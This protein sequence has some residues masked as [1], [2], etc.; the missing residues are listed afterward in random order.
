VANDQGE[1]DYCYLQAQ[2]SNGEFTILM[3]W[4]SAGFH[5][6][7]YNNDWSLTKGEDFQALV[8]IDKRFNGLIAASTNSDVSIDYVFGFDEAPRKAFQEGSRIILEG[9]AGKK[10]FRLQGTRKAVTLLLDCADEYF[11]TTEILADESADIGNPFTLE[12]LGDNL[13]AAGDTVLHPGDRIDVMF[14]AL[15]DL[16]ERS[17][18]GFVADDAAQSPEPYHFNSETIK[19]RSDGTMVLEVPRMLG[20]YR[21]WMYDRANGIMLAEEKLRIEVDTDSAGLDLPGGALLEPGQS[22]DVNFRASPNYSS[23]AWVGVLDA[24][25]PKDTKIEWFP[26]GRFYLDNRAD[27]TLTFTAPAS[28]GKYLLRMQEL[29]FAT[30]LTEIMLTVAEPMAAQPQPAAANTALSLASEAPGIA[31][32]QPVFAPDEGIAVIYGGLPAKGQDWLAIAGVDQGPKEYYDLVM[33][34]GRP[35]DGSHVFKPLPEGE[36]Q[37]RLYTDWPKGGYEI[38]A[39]AR[40][41]VAL[42]PALP[43]PAQPLP[44]PAAPLPAQPVAPTAAVPAPPA[45]EPPT[46][47]PPATLAFPAPETGPAPAKTEMPQAAEP[48]TPDAIPF[49]ATR[50]ASEEQP[51]P[52]VEISLGSD[53]TVQ[54]VY[55]RSQSEE[56]RVGSCCSFE[57]DYFVRSYYQNGALRSEKRSFYAGDLGDFYTDGK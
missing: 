21:L 16:S 15:S 20:N 33:L 1:A 6:I 24:A 26:Y 19:N 43:V 42:Q 40:V 35:K 4:N 39:S 54:T 13:N 36:Y 56:F 8:R 12:I 46:S 45:T 27:G 14:T 38:I 10:D 17:W 51:G 31:P 47:P 5:I 2:K 3:L 25:T 57:H 34:E 9:P 23:Y 53:G 52:N 22:F 29:E 18:I 7:L 11:S 37:I 48:A 30:T 28:P 32:R 41:V 50:R 49:R 55:D 44:V